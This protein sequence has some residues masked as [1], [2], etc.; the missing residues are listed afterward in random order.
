MSYPDTFF[1]HS[2]TSF[3]SLIIVNTY[4]LTN[5]IKKYGSDSYYVN[6]LEIVKAKPLNYIR[7]EDKK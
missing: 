1:I 6:K 3:V 4:F 7:I 5:R 2:R